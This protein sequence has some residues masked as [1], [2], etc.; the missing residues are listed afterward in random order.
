M[1][2][3]API[4]CW[5]PSEAPEGASR[6]SLR[7][8]AR[9]AS[10]AA[11]AAAIDCWRGRH[12]SAAWCDAALSHDAMGAPSFAHPDAPLVALAHTPGLGGAAIAAPGAAHLGIDAEPLQT[13]AA[14]A[15]RHLS[16]QTGEAAL[17]WGDEHWPLRLWC[18]KE[19]VVKAERSP[20]DLLGRTLRVEAVEALQPDGAQ[21]L[22]VRSHLGRTF[23]VQT[24]LRGMHMTAWA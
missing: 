11:L 2:E 13:H 14:R 18:A 15:L 21:R 1:Q 23:V 16:E 3:T 10:R 5:Q 20:A 19:A 4:I 8:A 17:P 12:G 22:T 6:L 7:V 9:L 24:T